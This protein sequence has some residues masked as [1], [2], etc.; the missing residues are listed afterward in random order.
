[1]TITWPHIATADNGGDAVIFYWLEW[2][3]GS[4]SWTGLNTFTLGMTVP[5]SFTHN[6]ST[7]L[8]SGGTYKYRL[9]A[10]NGVGFSI[11]S[12]ETSIIADKIPETCNAPIIALA[13]IKP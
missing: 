5:T 3:Q 13:D 11:A 6:P 4:D 9:Y 7:I 1:M 2:D 8:T 12:T 10:K